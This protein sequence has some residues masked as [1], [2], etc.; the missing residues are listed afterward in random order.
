MILI[1]CDKL[2][3][4]LHYIISFLFGEVL[5]TEYKITTSAE[6]ADAY[7]GPVIY[8]SRKSKPN[9]V[10]IIPTPSGYLFQKTLQP[11]APKMD[12]WENLPILFPNAQRQIPFDLF[13]ASFWLVTRHEEYCSEGKQDKH[14]RFPAQASFAFQH[15]FLQLP[16]IDLWMHKLADQ[17]RKHYIHWQKPKKQFSFESTI[18]VDNAF[19]VKHKPAIR[20]LAGLLH[21]H[22]Q[23]KPLL[24]ASERWAIIR[25]KA[26]DPYD[27]LDFIQ[28]QH[29]RYNIKSRFFFLL[30]NYGTFDKNLSHRSP[31]YQQL[32]QKIETTSQVGI[33]PSYRAAF[34][35]E[36]IG[37]E[38][39]RLEEITSKPVHSSRH[40]FLRIKLPETY[41]ALP[42]AGIFGDYSM[43]YPSE[44]GFRAG[45]CTP[46]HFFDLEKNEEQSLV[47]YPLPI[48]DATFIHYKKESAQQASETIKKLMNVVKMVN[49]TFISLFHNETLTTDQEGMAWRKVF[50][51][52][53]AAAAPQH[54]Q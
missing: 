38:I 31:A 36:Q 35:P 1:L 25:N 18:D 20:Q 50:V 45:T 23:K 16:V 4:R 44:P 15:D 53:L 10:Q 11:V 51:K 13:A 28:E 47:I 12:Y 49:G 42:H 17:L 19:A 37:N 43:G 41:R 9:S 26:T 3:V 2:S 30:G 34:K 48:M 29:Q 40:H 8:Y 21:A 5:A 46:F 33:H 54:P 52:M 6:E 39:Q 7:P 22:L 14:Q 32:I 24:S 27:V